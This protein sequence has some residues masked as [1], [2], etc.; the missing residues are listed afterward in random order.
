MATGTSLGFWAET[1]GAQ[2][3][4]TASI[5][6]NS[7]PA[8]ILRL[9]CNKLTFFSSVQKTFGILERVWLLDPL[10]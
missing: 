8:I 5:N 6:T 7:T 1:L 3:V 4:V 2:A 10:N 9:C